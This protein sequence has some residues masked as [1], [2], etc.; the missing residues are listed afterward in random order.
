MHYRGSAHRWVCVVAVGLVLPVPAWA[1]QSAAP[2]RAASG[3]LVRDV[4]L[5]A[6]GQLTGQVT[7]AEG[8]PLAGATVEVWA[9]GKRTGRAVTGDKGSFSVGPLRGGVYQ[10]R[11]G[12]AVETFRLWAGR[13]APPAAASQALLV[14]GQTVRGQT[15]LKDVVTSDGFLI[16]TLVA[17]AIAVPVAVHNMDDDENGS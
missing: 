14:S 12:Q 9:Q 2:H 11:C 7:T 17:A 15:H 4:A 10:L 8:V 3:A 16:G 1:Q 5:N 6:E 13:A